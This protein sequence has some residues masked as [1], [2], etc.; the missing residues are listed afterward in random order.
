MDCFVGIGANFTGCPGSEVDSMIKDNDKDELLITNGYC[1]QGD[2][3]V[4]DYKRPIWTL[5]LM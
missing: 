3:C 2:I 1:A 5:T 4:I